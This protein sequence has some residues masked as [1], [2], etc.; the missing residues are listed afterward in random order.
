[1][2]VVDPVS[3]QPDRVRELVVLQDTVEAPAEE[4]QETKTPVTV[5]VLQPEESKDLR[6]KERKLA[7]EVQH[8]VSKG[9]E[10]LAEVEEAENRSLAGN[11]GRKGKG[12][13]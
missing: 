2:V 1:V 7:V 12:Y 5:A 8:K 4:T 9:E 6:G 13:K 3:E 10:G 11:R